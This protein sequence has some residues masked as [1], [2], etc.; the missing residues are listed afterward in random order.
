MVLTWRFFPSRWQVVRLHRRVEQTLE[1]LPT[2]LPLTTQHLT[3]EWRPYPLIIDESTDHNDQTMKDTPS[4]ETINLLYQRVA[5]QV[6]TFHPADSPRLPVTD[7]VQPVNLSSCRLSICQTVA[8]LQ[9]KVIRVQ[10]EA[11]FTQEDSEGFSTPPR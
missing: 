5:L 7:R 10:Q 9:R 4:L 11:V 3:A 6:I 2:Q 1:H 8:P